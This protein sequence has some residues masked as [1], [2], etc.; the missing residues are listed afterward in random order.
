VPTSDR[1]VIEPVNRLKVADAVAAQL[2]RLIEAGEY[3]PDEKLPPERVLSEQFGVGRSSMREALRSLQADGL[4]RV[5]HGIG[6][7]AV[8][9]SRR[10]D[11][12]SGMLRAGQFTVPELFEVRLP[13]E[14]NA[15][16]L[17]AR[18]IT[19]QEGERLR[20]ILEE[21]GDPALSDDAFIKLDAQL[22][23]TVVEATK[24]PLLLSVVQSIEPLFFTYS[25]QV[26][27]LPGRRAKAHEGHIRIVEAV[28]GR[29]VREA[30]AAAVAHIRD[31]ERD[32]V[33]YLSQ[34][35]DR[36]GSTPTTGRQDEN[37]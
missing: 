4:V 16:G 11:R 1:P 28:I 37:G 26:M 32:I 2:G 29:R 13:L 10:G 31:V 5:E 21:A 30:R 8:D 36:R 25:H 3:K 27:T 12:G 34:G 35:S 19:V 18:R 22:H 20:A 15:A 6:V 23:R 7:F 9:K 17:A 33:T 24:N 14:S